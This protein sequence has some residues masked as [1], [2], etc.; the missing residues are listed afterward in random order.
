[1]IVSIENFFKKIEEI[2]FK[3][4]YRDYKTYNDDLKYEHYKENVKSYIGEEMYEEFKKNTIGYMYNEKCHKIYI[5]DIPIIYWFNINLFLPQGGS[6]GCLKIIRILPK[7][8]FKKYL[9]KFNYTNKKKIIYE[10]FYFNLLN[11]IK[12]T[13]CIYNDCIDD[14]WFNWFDPILNDK[15]LWLLENVKCDIKIEKGL[16]YIDYEEHNEICETICG[17]YI[18]IDNLYKWICENKKTSCPY[19]RTE[20]M[21]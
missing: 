16:C 11:M 6:I 1:M 15:T 5:K 13:E 8:T 10:S 19:C 17:H 14:K 9:D 12:K 7:D 21:K 18:S 4:S 2:D 20:I 3:D